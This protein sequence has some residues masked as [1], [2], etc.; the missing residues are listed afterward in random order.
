MTTGR[1]FGPQRKLHRDITNII[2]IPTYLSVGGNKR[3]YL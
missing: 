1:F 2:R 3:F